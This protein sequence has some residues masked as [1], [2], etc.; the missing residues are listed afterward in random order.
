MPGGRGKS[1]PDT[2]T[3]HGGFSLVRDS[4]KGRGFNSTKD[5]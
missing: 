1:A 2:G 5:F 4:R 3:N